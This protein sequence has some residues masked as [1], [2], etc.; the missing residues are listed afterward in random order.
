MTRGGGEGCVSAYACVVRNC[1][2][3]KRT[4]FCLTQ[5]EYI[6]VMLGD[7]NFEFRF[8]I[9]DTVGIPEGDFDRAKG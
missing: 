1:E 6:Y 7:E 2:S 4:Q 8:F 5:K 3:I 9:T